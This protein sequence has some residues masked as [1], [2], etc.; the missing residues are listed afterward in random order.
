[1]Q[2]KAQRPHLEE[3]QQK[4]RSIWWDKPQDLDSA[5]ERASAKVPQKPYVYHNA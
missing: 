2:L 5:E 4:G 1:E 3:Q